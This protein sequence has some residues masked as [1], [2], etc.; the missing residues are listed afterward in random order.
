MT[1]ISR[2]A[3]TLLMAI[4]CALPATLSAASDPP[5]TVVKLTIHDT[6]QPITAD[7]LQR[8]L[9]EAARI[10]AQAVLIS[11][12]TPGG[13]LESTRVMV[14]AIENS[15]V[16]VIIFIS[17]TGS[18]AGSAGF[19]LLESADIAAM[20]PG[21]NAGAAHPIVEGTKLDPILKQKIENDA[22][23]FL[24]SYTSRRGRNVEAAEDAVR[25]SKSY[26]DE[27]AL[28]LKLIDL[29]SLDDGSLLKALDGREIHR[30][31]G[32]TQTL[33]LQGA[34]IVATAPSLRERLLSKLTNPDI[35]VLLLVLGGLLIYLEFNVPG[36]VV[37]GSIGTLFVL[38]GLFGLNLLPV[39]HTAIVLL[40]A[41]V[42]MMLLE[43]KFGSHG[44]LA[45]A[46]IASLVF[47]LATLVD[48]PIP[49]LRVHL[50]TALGA[51]LG[52]GAISFGLAWIALRA[53]RSKVLTGPQAMIG[54][55]AVVRTPLCPTGQVEIRGELWQASLRGPESL[56][57]G[58]LVSVRDLDGL[59]LV[60]EPAQK[61]V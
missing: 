50:G 42:V 56:A 52:F 39:R 33:H 34:T 40:I 60:V 16:P 45:I 55:T 9:R 10:H 41:A 27:E 24:R 51:G 12:G 20:A 58:S 49:E 61:P 29:V 28:K 37:P 30:F 13:L 53:R 46:G 18:R 4:C 47:G 38:L 57:V 3:L 14:Q 43:A 32:T 35:A 19:F 59:V 5:G 17:P 1:R 21:T 22:A 26:S 31:D 44:V 2:F 6:I 7:Y 15:P 36:T 48:G 11:M 23:A 54:G 8:G 25:N